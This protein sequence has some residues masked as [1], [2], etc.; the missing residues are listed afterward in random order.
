MIWRLDLRQ[1]VIL[2]F[3]EKLNVLFIHAIGNIKNINKYYASENLFNAR[4][5][6]SPI[7]E[8]P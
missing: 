4:Y 1:K 7:G 3:G 5:G 6:I 2:R 8:I